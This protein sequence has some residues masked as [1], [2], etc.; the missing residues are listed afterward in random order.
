M[1]RESWR[2]IGFFACHFPK[3]GGY[4]RLKVEEFSGQR[5]KD[6]RVKGKSLSAKRAKEEGL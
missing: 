6:F 5:W 3:K 2:F 1:E 4:L